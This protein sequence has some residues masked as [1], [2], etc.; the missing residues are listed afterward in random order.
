MHASD[1]GVEA[2]F[3]LDEGSDY[4]DLT[5]TPEPSEHGGLVSAAT[6]ESLDSL[7]RLVD[8]AIAG[9]GQVRELP[10]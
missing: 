1:A 3:A 2:R 5:F 9:G 6:E 8:R 10:M 4:V 7:F